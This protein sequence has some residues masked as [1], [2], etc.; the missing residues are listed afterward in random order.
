MKKIINNFIERV[1]SREFLVLIASIILLVNGSISLAEFAS[2]NGIAV[3][4]ANI[5]KVVEQAKK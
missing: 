4:V 3:G 5:K 2:I 1:L